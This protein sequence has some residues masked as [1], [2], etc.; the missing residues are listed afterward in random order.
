MKQKTIFKKQCDWCKTEL[1]MNGREADSYV[2]NAEHL[3]FC[4]IHIRGKEPEKDCMAEYV[5][6]QKNKSSFAK[7]KIVEFKK[8]TDR[9]TAIKKLDELKQFLNKNKS[10]FHLNKL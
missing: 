8:L 2:I 3:I 1:T 5:E 7:P 10:T 4:K 6:D 9:N